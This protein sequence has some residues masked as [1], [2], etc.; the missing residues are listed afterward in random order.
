[1]TKQQQAEYKA[2]LDANGIAYEIVGKNEITFEAEKNK[3][4]LAQEQEYLLKR[5]DLYRQMSEEKWAIDEA[6]RTQNFASLQQALTDEYVM[7]QDNY[8]LRKEMLDEYQQAVMDSYFNTQEMWMGA[9]MSGIDA[10]QEGC[11]DFFKE[12]Q[13]WVKRLRISARPL[14]SLWPIML[15]IGRQQGLN[16]PFSERHFNSKK[17][18]QASQQPTLKYRLGRHS[19]SR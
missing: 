1:M 10:L 9:M 18:P 11:P 17:R 14:L 16:K 5:N 19:H 2:A 4:L 12:R 8:N 15:P 6:L 3:E 7:T 13:A